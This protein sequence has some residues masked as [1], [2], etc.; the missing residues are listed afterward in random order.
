M[1]LNVADRIAVSYGGAEPV[2]A[3]IVQF[4][5]YIAGETLATQLEARDPG[6]TAF[7]TAIDGHAFT[8]RIEVAG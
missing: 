1:D 4:A 5:E 3:A 7:T 6:A 8:Y 2:L